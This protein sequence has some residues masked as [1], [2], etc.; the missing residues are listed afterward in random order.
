MLTGK[1]TLRRVV[2]KV[3]CKTRMPDVC[4]SLN[5]LR[6]GS[7]VVIVNYHRVSPKSYHEWLSPPVSPES[8]E[9]QMIYLSRN[10]QL[11]PLQELTQCIRDGKPLPKAAAAVTL[12]DGY[13]DSYV[14][15]YPILKRY[16]VPA[17]FFLVTGHIGSD[18]LFWW[19][20]IRYAVYQTRAN[21][22]QLDEFGE[23]GLSSPNERRETASRVVR[24]AG[25]LAED[26]KLLAEG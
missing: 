23:F 26:Q 20:K 8:F 17:T 13:R 6:F 9:E 19:D 22:L 10:F 11:L 3:A 12:D 5:R 24:M 15:A 7:Q 21:K 18:D 2:S 14:H 25:N 1:M 16:H 4:T